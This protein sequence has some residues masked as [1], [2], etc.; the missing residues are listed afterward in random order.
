MI[1][2]AKM[3][4]IKAELLQNMAIL[5][6]ENFINFCNFSAETTKF[7]ENNLSSI[8]KNLCA[9]AEN[10]YGIEYLVEKY[11]FDIS[12]C[13]Y[14]AEMCKS[15]IFGYDLEKLRYVLNHGAKFNDKLMAIVIT[16]SN[17]DLMIFDEYNINYLD[18][19]KIVEALVRIFYRNN[20][21]YKTDRS[22]IKARIKFFY[23]RGVKLTSDMIF[24]LI[25]CLGADAIPLLSECDVDL[26]EAYSRYM[27]HV[28]GSKEIVIAKEFKKVGI[29]IGDVVDKIVAES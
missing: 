13:D 4:T 2:L 25:N 5:D 20:G 12:G 26:V 28:L 24:D 15:Y 19:S 14:L 18:E 22:H 23:N 3:N 27:E 11:N 21:K 29:Y 8:I 7:V 6:A 1:L 10:S 17:F 9:S 16:N